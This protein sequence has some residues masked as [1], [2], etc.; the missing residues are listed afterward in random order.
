MTD[1]RFNGA[2]GTLLVRGC[3]LRPFSRDVIAVSTGVSN[4]AA[5]APIES[6]EIAGT[7][8]KVAKAITEPY[9]FSVFAE[10][11]RATEPRQPDA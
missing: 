11:V 8:Y 3:K 7:V 1:V 9:G 4:V 2:G 5:I 10:R 6:V